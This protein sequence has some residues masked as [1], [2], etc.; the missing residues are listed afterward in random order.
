MDRNWLYGET[1]EKIY[2]SIAR[3]RPN[4]MPAWGT[5]LPEWQ[6]W[7]LTTY[8]RALGSL[9]PKSAT[10]ARS[11]GPELHSGNPQQT[12]EDLQVQVVK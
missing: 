11:D 2:E 7:Y 12:S 9:Q 8:V 1:P 10:P 6:I 4:G 5:R 3:G